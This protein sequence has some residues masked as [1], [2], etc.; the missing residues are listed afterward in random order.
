MYT[1]KTFGEGLSP[2]TNVDIG[3]RAETGSAS[4]ALSIIHTGSLKVPDSEPPTP[5]LYWLNRYMVICKLINISS[6]INSLPQYGM[7]QMLVLGRL[8]MQ[9]NHDADEEDKILADVILSAMKVMISMGTDCGRIKF[10]C[11]GELSA[12]GHREPNAI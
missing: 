6:A 12:S 5:H 2:I 1:I 3:S 4:R 10:L 11:A 9:L 7:V 8:S